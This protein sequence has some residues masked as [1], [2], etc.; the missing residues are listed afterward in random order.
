MALGA[1]PLGDQIG[2]IGGRLD[3]PTY[4]P[5]QVWLH[6]AASVFQ[7]GHALPRLFPRFCLIGSMLVRLLVSL[8]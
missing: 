1:K 6:S 7:S 4:L 8:D 2:A 3:L 5:E